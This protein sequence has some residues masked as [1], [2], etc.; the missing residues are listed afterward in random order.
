MIVGELRNYF[1]MSKRAASC[2]YLIPIGRNLLMKSLWAPLKPVRSVQ[3][4][5]IIDIDGTIE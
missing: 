4:R 1:L 5:N 2:S 3:V